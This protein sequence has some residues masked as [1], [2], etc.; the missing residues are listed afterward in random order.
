MTKRKRRVAVAGGLAMLVLLGAKTKM[1]ESEKAAAA[2]PVHKILVVAISKDPSIRAHFEDLFAGELSLKG[3]S[4]VASHRLF[5][6]LPSD[7]ASFEG[8]VAAEGFDAITF[9]RLVARTDTFTY[10][11]GQP[12]TYETDYV[13]MSVWGGYMYTAERTFDPGYLQ[14]ETRVRVR[15]DLYRTSE[16]GGKL[17]WS[18]TSETIDPH[19]LAQAGRDVGAAVAKALRKAKLL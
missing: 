17:A 3:A 13:G 15:T 4:A 16:T 5:P 14:K 7:K 6:E 9:S 12:F 19:T 18:G 2:G 1:A 8:K 10:V 11:E